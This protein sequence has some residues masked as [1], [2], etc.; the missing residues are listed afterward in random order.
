MRGYAWLEHAACRG[1]DPDLFFP[2]DGRKVTTAAKLICA[3]CPVAGPCAEWAEA[4]GSSGVWA[5]K[6]RRGRLAKQP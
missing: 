6:A 3:A 2:A 4:T 5:G 1:L